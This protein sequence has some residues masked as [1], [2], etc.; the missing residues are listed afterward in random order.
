[1]QVDALRAF[2]M[3]CK[4]TRSFFAM[5][6]LT[7]RNRVNEKSTRYVAQ[8]NIRLVNDE[9]SDAL[10]HLA[11]RYFRRW[12]SGIKRFVS[13]IKDEYPDD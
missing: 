5:H 4:Y 12:D 10:K 7:I 3:F 6:L 9:P 2:I 11:G 1:L 13:N 8:E